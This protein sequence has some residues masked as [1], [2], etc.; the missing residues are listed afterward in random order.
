M[1]APGFPRLAWGAHFDLGAVIIVEHLYIFRSSDFGNQK[2]VPSP[3]RFM[4]GVCEMWSLY[5][6]YCKADVPHVRSGFEAETP[7]SWS[8]PTCAHCYRESKATGLMA[9]STLAVVPGLDVAMKSG[10]HS[11]R[12]PCIFPW[13]LQQLVSIAPAV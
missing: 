4:V 9:V 8:H 5:P 6:G 10:T 1:Q 7:D 3:C 12:L 13:P 2:A 11:M